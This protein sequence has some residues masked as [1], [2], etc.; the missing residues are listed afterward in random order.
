MRI[1]CLQ[2]APKLGDVNNNLNRADA[3]LSKANPEDLDLLCLPELSFTGYNFKSLQQISPFL[4]PQGSGVSALWARTVALKYN[5]V[6]IVGYPESCDV[7]AKWPTGPEYYN[8]AIVINGEGE[9]IGNYRKS[10]LYYT[11]ETWAL[12]GQEGFWN[13]S[14]PGLGNTSLGICM[15]INPYKFEAPFH[16]FEFAFHILEMESNLVVLTM[17]WLTREDGRMFSRMPNDPDLETLTYWVTRLEPLIRAESEEE[18]IVV[19]A[20]RCGI[21]DDAVYAGT[22]AV[23]GIKDGEVNIY[24]IL[25]R[26]E[27]ELLVVDT[28][29]PPYAKL[30]YRPEDSVSAVTSTDDESKGGSSHTST[31]PSGKKSSERSGNPQSS[32]PSSSTDASITQTPKSTDSRQDTRKTVHPISPLS[33]TALASYESISGSAAKDYDYV[34]LGQGSRAGSDRSIKSIQGSVFSKNSGTSRKSKGSSRTRASRGSVDSKGS[35]SKR[36]QRS[37]SRKSKMMSHQIQIPPPKL[38]TDIIPTPTAPS[39]TPLAVRPKLTI[40]KD[41]HRRPHIPTPYPDAR[42]KAH[43]QGY[44][45]YS[46][47]QQHNAILTPTTAFDDLSPQFPTR[48]FWIP[49]DSLLRTPVESRNWTP[50]LDDTVQTSKSRSE[51]KTRVVGIV[52][53][54]SEPKSTIEDD[55][56]LPRPSSPKS[57]NASRSR[58]HERSDSALG[59]R[60]DLAAISQRLETLNSRPGSS[61]GQRAETS[62]PYPDRPSSPKS[63]NASRTRPVNLVLADDPAEQQH[64]DTARASILIAASPSILNSSAIRGPSAMFRPGTRM[65]N[66][67]STHRPISQVPRSRSNS[68]KVQTSSVPEATG[69]FEQARAISRGRQRV[70]K[71]PT[72]NSD[73]VGI[74]GRDCSPEWS[75]QGDMDSGDDDEI[76]EEIIVRRSP[77]CAIHGDRRNQNDTPG[78]EPSLSKDTNVARADSSRVTLESDILSKTKSLTRASDQNLSGEIEIHSTSYESSAETLDGAEGSP[79]TPWF[80]FD[81]KTPKA[82]VFKMDEDN[83]TPKTPRSAPFTQALKIANH[84]GEEAISKVRPKSAVW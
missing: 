44:E 12:E 79:A 68:Y 37:S 64:Y 4:E 25:G 2:F 31:K 28:D 80:L 73:H 59:Q 10:F 48:S 70:P 67:E 23:I 29:A 83:A 34:P 36:S 61:A 27:K 39:P 58:N 75:V 38:A 20:N 22:S 57:R 35:S 51:S 56:I 1:G 76:V 42:Q 6:T 30:V 41:A 63:R 26:G 65:S 50:A 7:K 82:M 52:S 13:G 72:G 49:S 45:G 18:I 3:V 53:E 66:V 54:G 55:H 62:S 15:D 9:T 21:E 47:T 46:S 43:G 71:G 81:P 16:A 84:I 74:N 32:G 17:A 19:F 33:E 14:I 40:P 5:C 77:S 8:S 11:D 24:G 69:S 60:P 78:Q